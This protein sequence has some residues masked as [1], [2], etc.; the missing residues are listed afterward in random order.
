MPLP[1]ST[2]NFQADGNGKSIGEDR[3]TGL[4]EGRMPLSCTK[5]DDRPIILLVVGIVLIFSFYLRNITIVPPSD[6]HIR[7]QIRGGEIVLDE[8]SKNTAEEERSDPAIPAALTPFFFA[9]IPINEADSE[10]LQ[11]V[12]GIGPH[13]ATEIERTRARIGSFNGPEDLLKVRGIG[14][15]KMIKFADKFSYR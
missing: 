14:Q 1:E 4:E 8:S 5:R 9:P 3:G 11:T 15:N 13:L 12:S 6:G 2:E 10:L 7:L